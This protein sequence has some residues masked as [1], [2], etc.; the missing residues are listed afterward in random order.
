MAVHD[1]GMTLPVSAGSAAARTGGAPGRGRRRIV[2]ALILGV[3]VVVAMLSW[4]HSR[5]GPPAPYP[6]PVGAAG[7]W[8]LAFADDFNGTQLD[9]RKWTT[10]FP[11]G[12]HSDTTPNAVYRPENVS[13][14]NGVVRLRADRD[15]A[16]EKPFSSGMIT[17]AG[18]NGRRPKFAFT[19]GFMEIRA[20]LPDAHGAWPAFWTL[21]VDGDWPPEIDVMENFGHAPTRHA[22]HFHYLDPQGTARDDGD[23]WDGPDFTRGFHTFGV[24]WS[25]D[26]IRWYVDGMERRAPFTRRQFIPDRPMYLLANLQVGGHKAGVYDALITTPH[27]LTIDYIRVWSRGAL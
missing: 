9:T 3:G 1:G 13:V 7:P 5:P 2:V 23:T 11:W 14:G 4:L 10:S 18:T 26:A 16:G 17:T 24:S 8:T 15:T 20:Q 25:P 19:Y 22:M 12:S 21:N 6:G 27:T